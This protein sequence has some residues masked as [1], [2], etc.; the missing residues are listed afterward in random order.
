MDLTF[1][2]LSKNRDKEISLEEIE[3]KYQIKA[4]DSTKSKDSKSKNDNEFLEDSL[5]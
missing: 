2:D 1:D 4:R 5:A 3:K